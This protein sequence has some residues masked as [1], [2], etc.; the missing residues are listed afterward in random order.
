MSAVARKSA[1]DIMP[2]GSVKKRS[3]QG[4]TSEFAKKDTFFKQ[5]TPRFQA[6]KL[7]LNLLSKYNSHPKKAILFLNAR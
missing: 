1:R 2:Y 4:K 5:Q 6:C 3:L 7:M